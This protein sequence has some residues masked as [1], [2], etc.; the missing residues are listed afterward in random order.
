MTPPVCVCPLQ[1]DTTIKECSSALQEKQYVAAAQ[2]LEKVAVPLAGGWVHGVGSRGCCP[3]QG[4][5]H[6]SCV[7][8][9]QA[10]S[11]LRSLESRRGFELK[12]L[13]ALGTELTVQ[14][15]NMIYHL[16]EEWQK[17]IVWKLPPSKG[18]HRFFSL[19]LPH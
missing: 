8:S 10:R 9:P 16:G 18:A 5:A 1:F 15:Q 2:Q 6:L 4:S 13:K 7:C 19:F 14:T 3:W 17:L 12:I 11:S